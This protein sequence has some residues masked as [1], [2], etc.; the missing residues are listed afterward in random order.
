MPGFAAACRAARVRGFE[1]VVRPTGGRAVAYDPSCLVVD[2]IE[3]ERSGR[4]DSAAAF[5]D[6]GDRFVQALRDVSVDARLGPVPG[7]YCPGDYSVNARAAVKLVG[8]AQ[9]ATRGA[10]LISASLPLGQTGAL[11]DVLE[12]VNAAL[13]FPW[14]TST[15]GSVGL[16]APSILPGAAERAVIERVAGSSTPASLADLLRP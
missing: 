9:R 12:A 14:D 8:T 4:R 16:E 15:F 13:A 6:I 7:E 10:R 3:A 11:V 5:I 1:P 2:V